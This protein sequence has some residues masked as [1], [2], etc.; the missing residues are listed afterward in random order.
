MRAQKLGVALTAANLLA[1]PP[2]RKVVRANALACNRLIEWLEY[3]AAT[4]PSVG[5]NLRP[6]HEGGAS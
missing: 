6:G 3:A 5:W 1:D 4:P 2:E